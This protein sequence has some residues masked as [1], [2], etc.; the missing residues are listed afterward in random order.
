M[1]DSGSLVLPLS[2][3]QREV[4]LGQKLNQSSPIYN[5]GQAAEIHGPIDAGL[6]RAA[7]GQALAEAEAFRAR[8]VD[9]ELGLRQI[10]SPLID[11]SI[12]VMDVSNEPDPRACADAWIE[13][14]LGRAIDPCADPLFGGAL[15]KVG[16]E[17]FVWYQRVHHVAVD[18]Y[19][20][21]LFTRRVSEI[22]SALTNCADVGDSPFGSLR[23]VVEEDVA[24]RAS[25]QYERDQKFWSDRLLDAPDCTSLAQRPL[26]T[27][28]NVL[29][30]TGVFS[31]DVSRALRGVA[32]EMRTGWSSVLV[33]A[34]AAYAHRLTESRDV[35]LG[36]PMTGRLTSASSRIPAMLAN[37]MPL[38][39]SVSPQ[40]RFSDLAYQ[41]SQEI[42][43]V[44]RHQRYAYEDLRRDI[45]RGGSEGRLFGLSVNILPIDHD[46]RFGGFRTVVTNLSM[47]PVEDMSVKFYGNLTDGGL[48][49]D[50]H[51]NPTG[52]DRTALSAH[53]RRLTGVLGHVV[54]DPGVAVGGI[55]VLSAD[56]R[57]RVLVE[58]NGTERVVPQ[59]TVPELFEAQVARTPDAIAVVCDGVGVSYAELNARANRLARHLVGF[60]L[61]PERLV[62]LALPRS[63]EMVVALLAVLKAGGAYLPIDPDYPAERIGFMLADAAPVA[64]VATRGTCDVLPDDVL[65][66]DVEVPRVVVDAAET[67]AVVAGLPPADLTDADRLHPLTAANPAYVIYTSGST[68]TPKGVMVEHR[69]VANYLS[70]T[71]SSYRGARRVSLVHSPISF[72]LTVTAL[73]TP[74]LVGGTLLL[75][76]PKPD[77]SVNRRGRYSYTFVKAT[78]S[79]LSILDTLPDEPSPD[80]ELVLGGEALTGEALRAWRTRHPAATVLNA[81]GPT[82]ATVNCVEYRI[83]PGDDVPAGPVPIGRPLLNTRVYVLDSGL[84]PVPWGVVGELYVAGAG[85]ARGYLNRPG[86]SAGRFVADPFG[87]VGERMYRTGDLVRWTSDGDLV[88][89]GR[90]DDQ[91]KLRGFRIELGE[92]E[93]ALTEDPVVSQAVV[94]LR[95]DRPGEKRL[96]GYVVGVDG[97]AVDGGVLRDRL[98]ERLPDYM[99]PVVVVGLDSLPL[100]GNGKLDRRALPAPDFSVVSGSRGPRTAEEEVL[101]GLFAEV[102]GLDRVGIDD[103]FFALGGDSIVSIQLV[104]RA[105]KAG[106]VFSLGQVFEAKTAAGLA[107]L[108]GRKAETVAVEGGA[109]GVGEVALTPIMWW[110]AR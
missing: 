26:S 64:V 32:R 23:S 8:F 110:L 43:E 30:R 51:L 86:L 102:L 78:P 70:W 34:A 58:W 101:C 60:G 103:D 54:A 31:T 89:V 7:F 16:P 67:A 3:G 47:G 97:A 24:Y 94:V 74:L 62:A 93:A 12:A 6:F 81:Y 17:L 55:D 28:P 87:G 52:Y 100:T 88:F 90:S 84:R 11:D 56:E 21:F 108:V 99:V 61:G 82:E 75:T 109:S 10:I 92:V 49:M 19:G 71:T 41:A 66:G 46:V 48:T 79:H 91:V 50:L 38:R 2:A 107:E 65:P 4:W 42:R 5:I 13:S 9:D 15:F 37:V 1:V 57:R 80:V 69:S 53:F 73:Y 59:V 72:D 95:E 76:E 104:S 35:V 85:L 22:Y 98:A 40:M 105:R 45:K 25:D 20:L 44:S 68:G 33:A 36:L 83:E 18:G 14:D 106:L 63:V 77:E 39:L 29:R 27:S 96:V